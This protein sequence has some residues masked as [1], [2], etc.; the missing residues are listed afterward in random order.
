MDYSWFPG[1][2]ILLAAFAVIPIVGAMDGGG[3]RGAW[4]AAKWYLLIMGTLA[5]IGGGCG[6]VSHLGERF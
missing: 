1:L 3:W 2:L 4:H 6:V 5:A